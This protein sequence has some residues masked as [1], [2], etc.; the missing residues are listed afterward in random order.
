MIRPLIRLI[1]ACL[2]AGLLPAQEIAPFALP[3]STAG[4]EAVLLNPAALADLEGMHGYF[5]LQQIDQENEWKWGGGYEFR[6]IKAPFGVAWN[7]NDDWAFGLGMDTA[8]DGRFKIN[9]VSPLRPF[10]RKFEFTVREWRGTVAYR[11]N[12]TFDIGLAIRHLNVDFSLAYPEYFGYAPPAGGNGWWLDIDAALSG[13]KDAWGAELS[14]LWKAK[15]FSLGFV[16]RP[17]VRFNFN[18]NDFGVVFTPSYLPDSEAEAILSTYFPDGGAS[19]EAILP[20]HAEVSVTFPP[21]EGLRL[22]GAIGWTQW[23]RW[24]KIDLN[25]VNN[26]VNPQTGE[27]VLT[28]AQ[29]D[30]A[31][32]DA[33]S[34]TCLGVRSFG[35]GFDV[36]GRFDWQEKIGNNLIDSPQ[37]PS[38]GIIITL[39]GRYPWKFGEFSLAMDAFYSFG[40]YSD[41]FGFDMNRNLL[42]A[43]LS[44]A[45]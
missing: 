9:S 1:A 13:E 25:Y 7:M 42:G 21:W 19:T 27:P 34:L 14:T 36:Y 10:F 18:S 17:E 11:V 44:V 20:L 33:F 12:D 40:I 29:F 3:S 8:Y 23:S 38:D 24:D 28:D 15:A 37:V 35:A 6:S 26:T 39:G 5:A 2:W 30:T 16:F 22:S 32:Q 45:Y 43:G 31:F 4:A 41:N